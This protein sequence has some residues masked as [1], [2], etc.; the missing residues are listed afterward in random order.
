VRA[1]L[2]SQERSL[3]PSKLVLCGC[4]TGGGSTEAA[5]MARYAD[6]VLAYRGAIV[7]EQESRTTWE[8]VENAIGL[9]EDVDRIKIVS[10]PMHAYRAR[11]Y[12]ARQRP[13]LAARLVRGADYRLGEWLLAKPLLGAYGRWTNRHL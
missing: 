5:L 12:L 11:V 6:Q 13:D 8:D 1:G 7:L 3:G 2:R 4:S 9:I 10:H